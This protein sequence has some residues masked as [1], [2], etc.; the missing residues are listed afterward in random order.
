MAYLEYRV[1]LKSGASS[2]HVS[3]HY[4]AGHKIAG[5]GIAAQWLPQAIPADD[6]FEL[7]A[8]NEDRAAAQ[9]SPSEVNQEVLLECWGPAFL[10]GDTPCT[11]EVLMSKVAMRS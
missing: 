9:P 3:G 11:Q 8:A 7:D 4:C 1:L 6:G 2:L 10:E 5:S